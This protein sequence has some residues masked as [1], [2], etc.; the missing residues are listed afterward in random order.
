[1]KFRCVRLI[2][3]PCHVGK[4]TISSLSAQFAKCLGAVAPN[5]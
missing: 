1:M 3:R 2:G 5:P 4:F